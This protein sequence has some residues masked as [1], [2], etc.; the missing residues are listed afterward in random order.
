M[1]NDARY[2]GREWKSDLKKCDGGRGATAEL[3]RDSCPRDPYRGSWSLQTS[4]G[5][6]HGELD[7]EPSL[8]DANFYASSTR[9]LLRECREC[10]PQHQ[11]VYYRRLTPLMS[12][13]SRHM[14]VST[15]NFSTYHLMHSTWKSEGNVRGEDFNLYSTYADAVANKN[16]WLFCNLTS[17]HCREIALRNGKHRTSGRARFTTRTEGLGVV[18]GRKHAKSTRC[19][20]CG[21]GEVWTEE[22]MLLS[23]SRSLV[24]AFFLICFICCA[25]ACV[26]GC[27]PIAAVL[28]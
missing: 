28:N 15:A 5:D 3:V 1:K 22:T 12:H 13:A 9:I 7:I 20:L 4:A 21:G 19:T 23:S 10:D 2:Y 11:T 27:R 16:P 17:L 6:S 26:Q 14:N 8:F 25:S 18:F 24:A